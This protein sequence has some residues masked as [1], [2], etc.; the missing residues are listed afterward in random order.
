MDCNKTEIFFKEL[1][2]MCNKYRCTK[3]N[4]SCSGCE[5]YQ[6]CYDSSCYGFIKN[7]TQEAIEIVQ[8]WS[9]EHPI[10]TR[11]SEFLKMFPNAE[12]ADDG[13]P[14]IYPCKL[15]ANYE[16]SEDCKEFLG[17]FRCGMCKKEYWLAEVE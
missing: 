17:G 5:I 10:K 14:Y 8:K 1:T 11:Q 13:M 16:F 2:R 3:Y 4:A 12:I 7:D 9:D 15:D 6:H